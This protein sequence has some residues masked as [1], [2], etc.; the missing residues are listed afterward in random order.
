MLIDPKVHT[1]RHDATT[2]LS[3]DAPLCKSMTRKEG[4]AW[5]TSVC[6]CIYKKATWCRM[7]GKPHRG[8][9]PPLMLPALTADVG[10]HHLILVLVFLLHF[11]LVFIFLSVLS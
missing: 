5:Q 1:E 2:Q 9:P 4:L 6:I 8:P 3:D 7:L 10:A 11:I